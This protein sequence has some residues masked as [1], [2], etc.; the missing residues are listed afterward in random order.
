MARNIVATLRGE[1]PRP[2]VYTP[3]GELAIIGKRTG[4]ASVYGLRFS[5]LLA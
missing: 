1:Q 5:G 2:F 3:I 4:V